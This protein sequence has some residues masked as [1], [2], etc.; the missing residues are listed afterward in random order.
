MVWS[1]VLER[2]MKMAWIAKVAI[3]T[4]GMIQRAGDIDMMKAAIARTKVDNTTEA[5]MRGSRG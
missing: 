2:R 4:A 3:K 1:S 5:Q